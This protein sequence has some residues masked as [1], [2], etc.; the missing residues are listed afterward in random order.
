LT[1]SPEVRDTPLESRQ[2]C[3]K[4]TEDKRGLEAL[5]EDI[6]VVERVALA[7]DPDTTKIIVPAPQTGFTSLFMFAYASDAWMLDPEDNMVICL[8]WRSKVQA[9][10]S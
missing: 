1:V 4:A 3:Q 6:A 9:R 7:C 5:K 8:V 2:A 10:K